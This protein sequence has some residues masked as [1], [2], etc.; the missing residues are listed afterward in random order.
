MKIL[1]VLGTRPE[2][3]RLSCIIRQI[4]EY[5]D[6]ILVFT[7]QNFEPGL[8]RAFF[9]ELKLRPPDESWGIRSVSAH[10]Q[11]ARMYEQMGETLARV[12]PD[13]VLILGD[14]N[15]GLT[16]LIA[17]RNQIPVYHLEA[18][19]RAYDLRVPEEVNRRVID[20]VSRVLMPYTYRSQENLVKEGI[21]RQRIVVVGNPIYEVMQC[22]HALIVGSHALNEFGVHP[23][24]Y[25]LATL[26]RAETVDNPRL[27]RQVI[28]ALFHVVD[29][30][31]LPLV[32]SLHPRTR[33]RL[34]E[35]GLSLQREGV[36]VTEPLSF[37]D[38]VRLE[39]DAR[40][41][42]TDSGTVQEECAILRVP[43]IT[44]RHVTERPETLECGSN[45]LAGTESSSIL[46]AARLA[47]SPA[48]SNWTPPP[49]YLIPDVSH[50]VSGVL[51]G[52]AL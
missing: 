14:T 41:V 10:A 6:Q 23:S 49:E 22:Y 29:T 34:Q 3:I 35:L 43:N 42:L 33:G 39:Q 21:E 15:S 46:R 5:A 24:Q 44:L 27:L 40:M 13:R 47:L 52:E 1:T 26:H 25:F 7:G 32:L 38:F 36:I 50:I 48:R 9:D 16:A 37:G 8:G 51:L 19:N 12:K 11:I 18:G 2:I 20:H 31:E 30:W 45:I 28:S 17:A 4:D